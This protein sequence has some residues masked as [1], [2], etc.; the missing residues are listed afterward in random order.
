VIESIQEKKASEVTVL[1]L[2]DITALTNYFILCNGES[3]PQIKTIVGNIQDKLKEHGIKPHHVEGS[4]ASG[5]VLL[6]YDD[7]VV[8]IFSPQKRTYYELDRLWV[9]APRL[10]ITDEP[11]PTPLS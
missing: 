8:H 3:E 6:D 1:N 9:D 7:F 11:Q 2:Q 5:W 4:A 10:Q